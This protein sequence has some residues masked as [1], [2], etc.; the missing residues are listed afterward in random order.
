MQ[1][2][3]PGFNSQPSYFESLPLTTRPKATV[4]C[5]QFIGNLMLIGG[6]SSTSLERRWSGREVKREN[7]GVALGQREPHSIWKSITK[8]NYNISPNEM[9][10]SGEKKG[11]QMSR[12]LCFSFWGGG[13][14]FSRTE[15][16]RKKNIFTL[17]ILA[18]FVLSS[19]SLVVDK[20]L[21]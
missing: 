15:Q 9:D 6:N 8:T 11:R 2:P 16:A 19:T 12:F 21:F 13:G 1:Y 18:S 7:V 5:R 17:I 4:L 14:A 20:I 3:V 10:R